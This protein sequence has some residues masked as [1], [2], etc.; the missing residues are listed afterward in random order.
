MMVASTSL[1]ALVAR[2]AHDRGH[3]SFPTQP[4]P[5]HEAL[6]RMD[7]RV[8]R[9]EPKQPVPPAKGCFLLFGWNIPNPK[10]S[11]TPTILGHRFSGF[12]GTKK[13]RRWTH[14]PHRS[15]PFVSPTGPSFPDRHPFRPVP[16][17]A[18]PPPGAREA[19]ASR[20]STSCAAPS[21][22]WTAV[23]VHV[24]AVKG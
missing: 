19:A 9:I 23:H 17:S 8:A 1:S 14:R 24:C 20:T 16:R 12:F 5:R 13:D 21:R 18:R 11:T 3:S 6:A 10:N 7:P 4:V 2:N 15:P 22:P